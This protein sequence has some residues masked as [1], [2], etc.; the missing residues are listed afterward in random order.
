MCTNQNQTGN[1]C[2]PRSPKFF[3]S[4]MAYGDVPKI[5]DAT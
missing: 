2:K 1:N 5:Y 3:S 4:P